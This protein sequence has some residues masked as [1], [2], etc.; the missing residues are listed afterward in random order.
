MIYIYVA[1]SYVV[2]VMQMIVGFW[3]SYEVLSKHIWVV[4]IIFVC[5]PFFAPLFL[6]YSCIESVGKHIHHYHENKRS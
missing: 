5:S 3:T 4:T 6:I 1:C 2:M